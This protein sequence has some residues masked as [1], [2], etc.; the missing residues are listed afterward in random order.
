MTLGGPDQRLLRVCAAQPSSPGCEPLA[1]RKQAPQG[2]V[3]LVC[4]LRRTSRYSLGL[5][6]DSTY[7]F[8]L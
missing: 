6:V 5:S 3:T 7:S 1:V 2:A 8:P 4:P